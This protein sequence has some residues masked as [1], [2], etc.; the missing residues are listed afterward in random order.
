[1]QQS[2][3][4]ADDCGE[5]GVGFVGAQRN[6]TE[7]FQVTEEILDKMPP[8]VHFLI[9]LEGFLALRPL[10]YAD[11]RSALVHLVDDPIA[12]ESFVGQERIE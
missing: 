2:G 1:M 8:F 3:A 12:V 11:R 5:A 6:P 9:D 7:V 10:G 4:G